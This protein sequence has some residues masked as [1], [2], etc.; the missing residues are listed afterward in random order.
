M[1]AV[2][3]HDQLDLFDVAL[4]RTDALALMTEYTQSESLRKHML[5]V[6]AAVRGYARSGE[7]R[8]RLGRRR[9]AARL[10]L[11]AVARRRE[12]SVPRRRDPEGA[13]LSRSG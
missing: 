7:R 4:S 1:L 2:A 9:A 8:G 3:H 10:R 13:G 6:E 11:R 12:P 5:A